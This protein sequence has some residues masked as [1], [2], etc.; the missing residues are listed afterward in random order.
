M[1]ESGE[2]KELRGE[3][4]SDVPPGMVAEKR[5]LLK[6]T[7]REAYTSKRNAR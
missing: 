1:G 7:L 3:V 6:A 4:R 2:G 5:K